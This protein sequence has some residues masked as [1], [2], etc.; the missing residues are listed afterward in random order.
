MPETEEAH[1]VDEAAD[2]GQGGQ[3]H[4]QSWRW[5]LGIA[6]VRSTFTLPVAGAGTMTGAGAMVTASSR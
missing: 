4:H 1:G 5:M 3:G 6:H 2:D